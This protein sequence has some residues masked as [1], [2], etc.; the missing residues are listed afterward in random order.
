MASKTTVIQIN[1][2]VKAL[3]NIRASRDG[4]LPATGR[5][6]KAEAETVMVLSQR[7]VPVDTGDLRD[8]G[9]V[10]EPQVANDEVRVAMRYGNSTVDY[11]VY[12]HE[13]LSA[14]HP[15]GGQAK[16]LEQPALAA[17]NGM[18]ARLAR[19]VSSDIERV[20]R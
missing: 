20:V 18:T 1:G 2:L 5:A 9:T 3:R 7:L 11:S 8:T 10:D 19:R 14:R 6:L 12:V 13:D 16:F 17:T 15:R 4:V